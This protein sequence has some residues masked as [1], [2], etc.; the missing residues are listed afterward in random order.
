MIMSL[1]GHLLSKVFTMLL[2][3]DFAKVK[4]HRNSSW[5]WKSL[6]QCRHLLKSLGKWSIGSGHNISV[7]NDNWS[8]SGLLVS[9]TES[10]HV[11]TVNE[12]MNSNHE[13]DITT[14]RTNLSPSSAIEVPKTLISSSSPEDKLY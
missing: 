12:L 13:W 9:L 10:A 8:S 1:I 5:V 14:I 7:S 2:R 6:L 11:S 4:P 3:T